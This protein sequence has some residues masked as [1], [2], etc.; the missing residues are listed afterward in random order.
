MSEHAYK[1]KEG[2]YE[3]AR[4]GMGPDGPLSVDAHRVLLL[5]I[6]LNKYMPD[7]PIC[8]P[9]IA[10]AHKALASNTNEELVNMLFSN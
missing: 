9:V 8:A 7:L 4:T 2:A 3:A 10:F 1:L 6:Y 5:S